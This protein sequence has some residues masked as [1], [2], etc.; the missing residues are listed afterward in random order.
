MLWICS[1]PVIFL[2]RLASDSLLLA[3]QAQ[4]QTQALTTEPKERKFSPIFNG[5]TVMSSISLIE[6]AYLSISVGGD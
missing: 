6:D 3:E 1:G 5:A 2:S 4:V